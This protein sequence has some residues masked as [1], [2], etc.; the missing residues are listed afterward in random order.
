M[1]NADAPDAPASRWWITP[2]TVLSAA[3]VLGI[4]W[5]T[6]RTPA[7]LGTAFYFKP[8][9]SE[10]TLIA[11]TFLREGKL[12][13]RLND[14]LYPSR[15]LP[16][17]SLSVLLPGQWLSGDLLGAVTAV[18]V[19]GIAALLLA[20]AAGGKAGP[21]GTGILAAALVFGYPSFAFYSGTAMTEI[22]YTALQFAVLWCY[23]RL[24]D[25]IQPR[26]RDWLIIGLLTAWC[27]AIRSS[28]YL[29]LALPLLEWSRIR[30]PQLRRP[31][32]LALVIPSV[33]M[34]LCGLLHNFLIF[35]TLFRGGYAYW[36][37]V[38][39]DYPELVFNRRYLLPN[40]KLLYQEPVCLAT[41]LA[42]LSVPAAWLAGAGRHEETGPAW[43]RLHFF[44]L[45]VVIGT[46][47]LYL[48]YFYFEGRLWLPAGAFSLLILAVNLAAVA[49]RLLPPVPA[50][51]LIL[52]PAI[53]WTIHIKS[54]FNRP[55][56]FVTYEIGMLRYC[57][58]AIPDNS[59]LLS[60]SDPAMA[61]RFFVN[62]TARRI[63][64][65]LR[66][67]EYVDK[68]TMKTRLADPD[69]FPAH[70]ADHRSPAILAAGIA[71]FP[72]VLEETPAELNRLLAE[73]H[74]VFISS[75][76]W[77]Q[78]IGETL[79]RQILERADM[80]P[81]ARSRWCTIYR[82]TAKPYR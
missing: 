27:G 40:L 9:A 31:A 58:S 62:G 66:W 55:P 38:P 30:Q 24:G 4:A 80:K 74:P 81:F 14:I 16:W 70:A 21:R 54:E 33:A 46:A 48:P 26:L 56:E 35:G 60:S 75:F 51:L 50:L 65:L 76:E 34:L 45:Y 69:P 39:Y 18:N 19:M 59:V 44:W 78:R 15:Y 28:G 77:E 72:Q 29:L 13:F 1:T 25:M 12:G 6:L 22:P 47:L 42:L 79:K 17:F 8:D 73:K 53:G 63:Y 37:P 49:G 67:P 41:V 82:L 68:V 20:M 57:H 2:L 52:L 7:E 64:P 32:L 3:L 23:L 11:D 10:Y 5:L 61:T 36:C 71:P 43:K